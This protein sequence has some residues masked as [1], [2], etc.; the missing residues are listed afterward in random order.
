MVGIVIVSHSAALAES[1]VELAREMGGPEVAVV[2]AGGVDAPEPALGTDA[3]KV[4][5]AIEQADSGQGVLVLMDLGSAVL[6]AE[7]AL[8]LL[9]PE[10][11]ERVALSDAPLVEGAVAA[12]VTAK[13][14][15]PLEQVAEEAGGGLAPKSSHL[16]AA[17]RTLQQT[18]AKV[19][20]PAA[21]DALERRISIR[22]RLGLHARPA[23]RFVQTAAGFDAEVSVSNLTAGR[24][25]ASARSLNALATLG[26]RQGHEILVSASGSAADDVLAALEALA[27]RNFDEVEA[28]VPARAPDPTARAAASEPGALTG[29]PA[30][31]GIALGPVRHLRS[32][33]LQLPT[34]AALDPEHEWRVLEAALSRVRQDLTATR[35]A[36]S[37]RAGDYEASI[38][39]AHLL[40]LEDEELLGQAR[41]AIRQGQN[42]AQAW[43]AAFREARAAWEALDDEYLRARAEDV[44]A[45]GRQVL[46]RLLGQAPAAAPS[47]PGIIVAPDLTPAQ[48]AALEPSVVHGIATAYGGPTSHSAILARSLGLPAVVGLGGAVLA[49][50]EDSPLALDGDAGVAYPNPPAEVAADYEGRAR[51]RA[52]AVRAARAA[53]KD[54]ATTRDGTTIEVAANVGSLADVPAALASGADGVGLLR[55][56]FLFLDRDEMPGEEEQYQAYLGIARALDG[57][58]LVLRTLDVGAD[59]PLPYVEQQPEANPYLGQRGL[60]L[61]L[62]RP[63]VLEIQLRAAL[64]VAAEHPVRIMFPMVS[65]IDEFRAAARLLESIREEADLPRPDVGVMVEVPSVALAADA[66]ADEVDFF[67]IGTNDLTQYTLAAER[68]NERVAAIADALHPAVLRLIQLVADAAR[69]QGKWVGVC[70]EL[71]G[72][73]LATPVLLGLGVTELSAAPP[74]VPSVRDA[75]RAVVLEDARGLAAEAVSLESAADVR[76]LLGQPEVVAR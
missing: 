26:V 35:D 38:F 75:V 33:E 19:P 31:P 74:L 6:A 62:A 76:D 55:T 32:A 18:V 42:A 16:G 47:A 7:M 30:A 28:D 66:F 59:K 67:S 4:V 61:G 1:V 8:D 25:P 23:A 40:F 27:E 44:A 70:G 65:T 51:A 41:Q 58:P 46:E 72:D 64:R 2:P 20:S 71:A 21:D 43:N 9:P 49:L 73:T 22:N 29:L 50:P 24:G 69:P 45:V 68:G 57:R 3:M 5:S 37:V 60:R 56:E 14:G 10:R 54:P 63:D 48:T 39:D 52:Q 11:R 34:H 12:A 36:V 17:S 53:A 13:A 15:A